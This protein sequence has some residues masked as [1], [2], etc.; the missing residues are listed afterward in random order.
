MNIIEIYKKY[1][2]HQACIEHLEKVRWGGIPICVYCSSNKISKHKEKKRQSR[3]QCSNC[4]KSF[5]VT[6]GTIMH[7]TLLDLQKWFLA[8]SLIL[9]A[10]KGISSRQLARDLDLPVKTAWSLSH[11][12]RKAMKQNEGFLLQGIVEMDETYVGG[13]PR[14]S[15]NKDKST[16]NENKDAIKKILKEVKNN[17]IK[18]RVN[19]YDSAFGFKKIK[20]GISK[21][22]KKK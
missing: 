12:I 9:N 20:K 1:P 2:N 18:S 5:S 11:K 22:E 10:K 16:K 13:K 17:P 4:K 3:W 8:I 15:N 21:E 19:I 6:V 14:K 7:S